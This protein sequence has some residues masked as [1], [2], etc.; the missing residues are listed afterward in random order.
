MKYAHHDDVLGEILGFYDDTIHATIPQPAV[1]LTDEEWQD[2]I[3]NNGLRRIDVTTGQVAIYTP[4]PAPLADYKKPAKAAID[5]AAG[6]ARAAFPSPG[7]L[8]D[9]EYYLAERQAREYKAAGYSGAVPGSVQSWA[10][11][12][13][14]TAQAA[15]DDIIA[16]ADQWYGV[17]EVI[18]SARLAGKAAV[19]AAA[20]H[21]AV[22][23]AA[24]SAVAALDTIRPA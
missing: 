10:D 22:D 4:P 18:R 11:A 24:A 16:T 7:S 13:G 15:A 21:A 17:L 19:D 23:A 1:P 14:M 8:V 2:C 5:N 20:D 3:D 12:S 9:A 6:N